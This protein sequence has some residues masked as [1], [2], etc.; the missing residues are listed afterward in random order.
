MTRDIHDKIATLVGLLKM[1]QDGKTP[2]SY[3]QAL[4]EEA[5]E[6][7]AEEEIKLVEAGL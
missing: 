3:M 6:F 2:P 1:W 7:L 4:I 5:E